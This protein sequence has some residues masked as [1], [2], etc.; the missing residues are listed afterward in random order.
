MAAPA[1]DLKTLR[2]DLTRLGIGPGDVVIVHASMKSIGR[3]RGGPIF[4]IGKQGTVPPGSA[5][6]L[7]LGVNDDDYTDNSG[8]WQAV[9]TVEHH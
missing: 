8:Y 5:G 4:E 1:L 6:R 2:A 3:V 7:Y 9:I